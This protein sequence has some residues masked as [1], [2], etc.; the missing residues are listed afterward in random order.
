MKHDEI[1]YDRWSALAAKIK[2]KYILS[3][4]YTIQKHKHE[5]SMALEKTIRNRVKKYKSMCYPDM[6]IYRCI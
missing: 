4:Y 1:A 3:K 6:I 5:Q 2:K